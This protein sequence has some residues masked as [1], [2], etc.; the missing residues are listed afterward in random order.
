VIQYH[1]R[2]V[3]IVILTDA[4]MSISVGLLRCCCYKCVPYFTV[5]AQATFSLLLCVMLH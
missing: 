4:V 2:R 5:Q 1:S 3:F